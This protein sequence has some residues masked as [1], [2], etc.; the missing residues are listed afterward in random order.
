[1]LMVVLAACLGIGSGGVTFCLRS[2]V[3]DI[4]QGSETSTAMSSTF[5]VL[6]SVLLI[7]SF[8]LLR[9]P[10]NFLATAMVASALAQEQDFILGPTLD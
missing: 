4:F 8:F 6:R 3:G 10:V 7:Q 2:L 5:F 9:G 1:M